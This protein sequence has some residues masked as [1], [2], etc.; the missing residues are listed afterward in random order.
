M[1]FVQEQA[2][3]RNPGVNL[4]TCKP[5]KRAATG[6]RLLWCHEEASRYA[7]GQA[8]A[9]GRARIILGERRLSKD[10]SSGSVEDALQCLRI[11]KS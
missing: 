1:R 9:Q 5:V 8:G 3:V 2:S 11:R 7:A 10:S 6:G 4:G